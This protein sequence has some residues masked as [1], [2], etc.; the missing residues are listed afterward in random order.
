MICTGFSDWQTWDGIPALPPTCWT[1]WAR[2]ILGGSVS[3]FGK[4]EW[5]THIPSS[6]PCYK[7]WAQLS[8]HWKKCSMNSCHYVDEFFNYDGSHLVI[9]RTYLPELVG[10]NRLSGMDMSLRPRDKGWFGVCGDCGPVCSASGLKL[11]A[12]ITCSLSWD[13]SSGPWHLPHSPLWVKDILH[14][15]VGLSGASVKW[16]HKWPLLGPE[17][18]RWMLVGPNPLFRHLTNSRKTVPVT[19][20]M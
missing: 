5:Y 6:Q 12:Y 9:Q 13:R 10:N 1:I 7:Y 18:N 4:C 15:L 8:T 2:Q 20:P 17:T 11:S 3:S 19:N 14:M 16:Q